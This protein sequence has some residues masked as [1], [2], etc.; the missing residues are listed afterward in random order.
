MKKKKK[1]VKVRQFW[2]KNPATQVHKDLKN[3]Y[4]RSKDK[5]AWEEDVDNL[6]EEGDDFE[7]EWE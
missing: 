2:P 6:L 3:D 4:N 5:K 1:K 7:D